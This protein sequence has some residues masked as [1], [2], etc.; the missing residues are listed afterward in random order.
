MS[1]GKVSDFYC[2][3]GAYA[4]LFFVSRKI[5]FPNLQNSRLTDYTPRSL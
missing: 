2:N 3:R 5:F 4:E 1:L